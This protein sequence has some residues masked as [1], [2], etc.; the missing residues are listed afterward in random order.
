M[1]V[2]IAASKFFGAQVVRAFHGAG[3][4]LLAVTSPRS[5]CGPAGGPP[6]RDRVQEVA[7]ELGITWWPTLDVPAIDEA[8]LLITAYYQRIIPAPVLEKIPLAI[9]YHPSLLPLHRGPD[10]IRWSL[11]AGERITGGSVYRLTS[12][13]DGGPLLG[14]QAVTIQPGDTPEV[15]WR[16]DLAP[17]G[18]QM[19]L[20]AADQIR[21]GSAVFTPQDSA[22]ATYESWFPRGRPS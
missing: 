20:T 7:A 15:L 12:T 18:V 5:S 2:V 6:A 1:N 16:R 19:L 11:A 17:L 4:E 9:G 21:S 22:A 13:V 8:D 10:A 3:F 14:Q